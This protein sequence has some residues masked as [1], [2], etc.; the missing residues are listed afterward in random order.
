[1]TLHLR[2]SVSSLLLISIFWITIDHTLGHVRLYFPPARHPSLDF[3]DSARTAGPCGI[4]KPE[5]GVGVRTTL[6]AGERINI[7][8]IMACS[9]EGG[10]KIQLLDQDDQI[11]S[12]LTPEAT[13]SDRTTTSFQVIP[14][15]MEC[16]NCGLRL[17]REAKELGD[18]YSFWSCADVD[19]RRNPGDRESCSDHG[20]MVAGSCQCDRLYSNQACQDKDECWAGFDCGDNGECRFITTRSFP[21]WACFCKLGWFGDHC[22]M[23]S[24]VANRPKFDSAS[25]KTKEVQLAH[26]NILVV[27]LWPKNF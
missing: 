25:Y 9:H 13:Q 5:R 3:L 1:M 23:R 16:I 18:S 11:M 27:H 2:F 19:V 8:W 12:T 10:F 6:T 14:S 26:D 4:A 20:T 24:P 21:N 22:N 17:V 15:N 7:T